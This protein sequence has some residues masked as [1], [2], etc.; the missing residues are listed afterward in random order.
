MN[1][2][3]RALQV[4][5]LV[6]NVDREISL[7]VLPYWVRM[8]PD[9]LNG[10]FIGQITGEGVVNPTADKSI[11]LNTRILWTFSAAYRIYGNR[12]FLE[13]ARRSFSYLTDHF[14]D[15]D[16]GGVYWSVTSKGE[17][18]DST[19]YL[20]AHAFTLYGLSEFCR[21]EPGAE[22]LDYATRLY[23]LIENH[24]YCPDYNGYHE[25]FSRVWQQLNGI[26]LGSDELSSKFSMN[27]HLHL[28]EAYANFYRVQPTE[29]LS[30]RL[31]NLIH[32][33]TEKMFD[34]TIGHFYSYFDKNWKQTSRRYSYGHDIEA[35]WL[36]LDAARMLNDPD[37]SF[38]VEAIAETIADNTLK[39]GVD[40]MRGGLYSAGKLGQV[41]DSN[42]EWWAQ[43]EAIVGFV[44]LW[45]L[46]GK[47]PYLYAAE[48]IWD[49]ISNHVKDTTLGEW[50]FL[51][52]ADG[53]PYREYDKIGPWKCPYHSSRCAMELR[54]IFET[55]S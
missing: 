34:P 23:N 44:Y 52:D 51:V 14:W 10:G 20:Y 9:K 49:F 48:S 54:N 41:V 13:L 26:P 37:L 55:V 28:M 30:G 6:H 46:H 43:A 25:V 3:T 4:L 31:R 27:T 7:E 53:N 16:M 36:L 47:E 12:E 18:S 21:I 40:T 42:K 8:S 2:L 39:E 17:P 24:C 22:A 29:V 15:H 1:D 50:F 11:I 38:T 45:Q 32:L 19:K 35:A 5:Q 33:H